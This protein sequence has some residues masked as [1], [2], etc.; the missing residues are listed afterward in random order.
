MPYIAAMIIATQPVANIT[1]ALR[2]DFANEKK[3]YQQCVG[4]HELKEN[5]VGP[6]HC[7]V[8]G[9]P[10]AGIPDYAYSAPMREFDLIWNDENL[11]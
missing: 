10:A 3:L 4:W 11:H 8:V 1:N 7:G 2:S 6:M 9:H 5:F